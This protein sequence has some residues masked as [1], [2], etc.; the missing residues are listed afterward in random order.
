MEKQYEQNSVLVDAQSELQDVMEELDGLK[1]R[2]NVPEDVAEE[3][4]EIQRRL[5]S[6]RGDLDPANYFI[7][8][9]AHVTEQS[10]VSLRSLVNRKK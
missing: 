2:P 7:I 8:R 1:K 9:A 6:L 5:K 4:D 10:H 3:L